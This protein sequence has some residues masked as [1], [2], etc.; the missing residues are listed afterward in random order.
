MAQMLNQ[1]S[2]QAFCHEAPYR[3]ILLQM[4]LLVFLEML[5]VSYVVV[6]PACRRLV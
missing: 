3:F 6:K 1:L 4:R 5:Q 2:W